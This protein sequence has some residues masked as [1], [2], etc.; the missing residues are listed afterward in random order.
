[1]R[2]GGFAPPGQVGVE[3]VGV[4]A[5]GAQVMHQESS[6]VSSTRRGATMRAQTMEIS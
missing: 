3:R 6:S 4:G 5:K 1:M 2:N